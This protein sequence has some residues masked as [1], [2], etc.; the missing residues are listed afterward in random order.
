MVVNMGP[1][2]GFDAETQRRARATGAHSTVEI[3]AQSSSRLSAPVLQK[4]GREEIIVVCPDD[5][6][7]EQLPGDEGV[8]VIVSHN[9]YVPLF[10]LT[11]LRRLDL[12]PDGGRLW[13][14][15]TI[16][17]RSD[18]DRLVFDGALAGTGR[19]N[20]PFALRFHMH[21][22]CGL[23]QLG[24]KEVGISLA[25]G[26]M[27]RFRLEGAAQPTLEPSRYLDEGSGRICDSRQIVC[28]AEFEKGTAQ[29]RWEIERVANG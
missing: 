12:R 27:W 11:H 8:T 4:A 28:Y 29:L 10:G 13:A 7:I 1:G 17:A 2:A 21:P 25:N 23:K 19:S 9:G 15:D 14:E 5:I 26:E 24:V 16:W 18:E 6:R 3:D 22:D 20:L